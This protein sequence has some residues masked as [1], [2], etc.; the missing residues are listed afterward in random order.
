M[1]VTIQLDEDSET[2]FDVDETHV[3]LSGSK[4]LSDLTQLAAFKNIKSLDLD[5]CP[6]ITDLSPLAS[7]KELE[8]LY[9]RQCV[10]ITDLSPLFNLPRLNKLHLDGCSGLPGFTSSMGGMEYLRACAAKQKQ[11]TPAST[12]CRKGKQV[13][14]T[15]SETAK[16]VRIA[17]RDVPIDTKTLDL[18]YSDIV[19]LTPISKLRSLETLI[20]SDCTEVTDL[21]PLA[22]LAG[23]RFLNLYRTG[24]Q[25][26]SPLAGLTGLVMLSLWNCTGIRDLS[27]LAALDRLDRL[28]LEGCT[29]VTDLS[30]IVGLSL[31]TL[32]LM[33]CT[34]LKGYQE[35][36]NGLEYL[37]QYA[38]KPKIVPP[39]ESPPVAPPTLDAEPPQET[40]IGIFSHFSSAIADGMRLGVAA[41]VA[42]V[43]T[44]AVVDMLGIPVPALLRTG[45]GSALLPVGVCYGIAALSL[46]VPEMTHG[47]RVR[48]YCILGAQG[49]TAQA[50]AKRIFFGFCATFSNWSCQKRVI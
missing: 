40:T 17:G 43:I 10:G 1:R 25:D 45:P 49:A 34:G 46:L 8:V 19:D 16:V 15:T 21:S 27:P 13:K 29:G 44:T 5:F 12:P 32:Y 39:Q 30:P 31:G 23:L 24:I 3:W 22:G 35:G 36:M 37:K 26:L 50:V 38:A 28:Y 41:K 14:A 2:D 11:A 4:H 18:S 47:A 42:R 9:L 7:L 48:A 6:S 20:L 33:G